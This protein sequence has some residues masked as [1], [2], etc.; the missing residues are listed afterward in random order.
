MLS[1]PLDCS[2]L[3]ELKHTVV[4]LYCYINVMSSCDITSQLIQALPGVYV[5][6]K[7]QKW[8]ARKGKHHYLRRFSKSRSSKGSTPSVRLSVRITLGVPSLCNL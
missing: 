1:S 4:N 5:E 6:I 3:V 8:G 7:M 2:L